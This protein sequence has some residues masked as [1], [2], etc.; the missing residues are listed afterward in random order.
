[1]FTHMRHHSPKRFWSDIVEDQDFRELQEPPRSKEVVVAVPQLSPPSAKDINNSDPSPMCTDS[2][3]TNKVESC[4]TSSRLQDSPTTSSSTSLLPAQTITSECSAVPVPESSINNNKETENTVTDN[5]C[6]MLDL[7]KNSCAPP[8]LVLNE[9]ETKSIPCESETLNK[10]T[11]SVVVE[12][13]EKPKIRMIDV[14]E[15]DMPKLPQTEGVESLFW[16]PSS[17][18]RT[19]SSLDIDSDDQ[20]LFCLGRGLGTRDVLG[21]RVL[22]IATIMRNLSFEEDNIAVLGKNTTFVR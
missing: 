3:P 19:P 20:D 2:E 21:Q 12:V 10:V 11:S 16:P 7:S 15:E 22:Q 13:K 8:V 14:K 17:Q 6:E 18:Q 4:D 9:N 5:D 1:M